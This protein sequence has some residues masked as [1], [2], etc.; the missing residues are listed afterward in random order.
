MDLKD[1][2]T[3]V[4]YSPLKDL[5]LEQRLEIVESRID[6]IDSMLNY[7]TKINTTVSQMLSMLGKKELATDVLSEKTTS[8]PGSESTD[9]TN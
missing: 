3:Q 5:T 2:L 9:V 7:Q 8:T 1:A 4:I 6:H